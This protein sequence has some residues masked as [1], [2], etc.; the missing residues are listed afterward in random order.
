MKKLLLLFALLFVFESGFP[1]NNAADT[2]IQNSKINETI[3]QIETGF[4][5]GDVSKISQYISSQVYL[6][7]LTDVSGYYSS[8]QA[9][10]ILDKFFKD[11]TVINFH[12]DRINIEATNP[13]ATGIYYYEHK[14]NRSEAKVYLS[15]KLAYD[16][17]EI[18]QISID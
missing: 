16:S 8:N 5:K 18:T 13:Y 6:S 11:Y 14:G 15:L 1:K 4:V 9:Y 17:W 7:I 2:L 10:Y 12:F 3:N